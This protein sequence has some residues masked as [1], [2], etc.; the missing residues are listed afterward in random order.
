MIAEFKIGDMVGTAANFIE[1]RYCTDTQRL[2]SDDE[3]IGSQFVDSIESVLNLY[4]VSSWKWKE[5]P[6]PLTWEELAIQGE[7][8]NAIK[9]LQ[10]MCKVRGLNYSYALGLK[11][12]KDIVESY[13]TM[14]NEQQDK[15]AVMQD[16]LDK[17]RYYINN[18][19]KTIEVL[20][21]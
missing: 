21:K 10:D 12:A 19:D 16:Q 13:I 8:I 15:I 14:Y 6:K 9:A 1:A 4:N 5:E 18:Q 17:L 3:N 20:S 7:K 11:Q 2:T